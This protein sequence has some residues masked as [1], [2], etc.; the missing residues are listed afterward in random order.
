MKSVL[1][2]LVGQ[3]HPLR[4]TWHRAKGVRAARAYGHPARRM[5]IIGITGTDGKTT[6]TAMT[7]AILRHARKAVGAASTTFFQVND[8]VRWNETHM[9]SIEHAPFQK[10][11]RECADA[12]CEFFV[13]EAASH[14]LVQG[15]LGPMT[16]EVA[17]I[18]NTSLEH[19]DYHGTMEQYRKDKG[20]LFRMLRGKG[21]KVLNQA[22]DTYRGY[23]QIRSESTIAYNGRGATGPFEGAGLSL[24]L[25]DL[26][27]QPNSVSATMHDGNR[28]Y[29]LK[30]DVPGLFNLE[31]ALCAIACAHAVG[32]P[33]ADCVAGV[34][35]FRGVPGRL[36]R[37]D[38]GQPFSVFVDFTVTPLAYRKTL[39]AIR[40]MTPNGRILCLTGACGN[41][42]R[43]KRPVIGQICSELADVVVVTTDETVTEDPLT[44][45]DE[46]WSGVDQTKTEARKI[47]DRREAIRWLLSQAKPGD[48]VALCGMGACSTMQSREGLVDW[49][50]REVAKAL[51]ADLGFRK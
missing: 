14:G 16:P 36:E 33:L 20:L 17:A 43:E 18:T 47:V 19:L 4:L 35:K 3:R 29:A 1:K 15:R 12:G 42:M 27:A 39:E 49:D 31:N 28:T 2:G 9:T 41:R 50:E 40:A 45:I 51:L 6:T 22:D 46:V 21:T 38:A 30:L 10:F 5:R 7:A 26:A 24:W 44:I 37:I 13:A 32:V 8:D 11:L 48:A 23:L 34:A 25:T